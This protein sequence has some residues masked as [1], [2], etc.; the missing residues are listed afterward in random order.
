MRLDIQALRAIAVVSVVVY[1]VFGQMLPGG[2]VG[3]DIFFVISGYLITGQL[4]RRSVSA[5]RIQFADFWAR[6]ARR[7]LPASL[8]VILVTAITAF[9][10]MPKAQVERLFADVLNAVLYTSNWLFVVRSTNYSEDTAA[11]SPFQHFWSLS[12]EEQYYIL[13]PMLMFAVLAAARKF[14]QS[15]KR[16]LVISLSAVFATSL[17]FSIWLAAAMPTQAYFSTFTRAWEFAFGALLAILS[18]KVANKR[19]ASALYVLALGSLALVA[20]LFTDKLPFPSFW[21]L[22]P[23]AATGLALVVGDQRRIG[24]VISSK[25]IQFLGDLSYS[26]YLWH[27]A[28]L[29]LMPWVWPGQFTFTKGLVVIAAAIL[30]AWISKTAIEDPVRFGRISSFRPQR[31]LAVFATLM[32]AVIGLEGALVTI[33][34]ATAKV[35]TA[36][37][38]T[39]DAQQYSTIYP[40][41]NCYATKIGSKLKVCYGGDSHGKFKV[42]LIGDS[43]TRQYWSVIENMAVRNSWK[44]TLLSKSA[45]PLQFATNFAARLSEPSCETWNSQ[46]ADYLGKKTFDLIINSNAS[47]Y[48]DG[49]PKVSASYR[50][51]VAREL[52]KGTSWFVIKDNPKPLATILQCYAAAKSDAAQQC[53]VSRVD[54]MKPVDALPAAIADLSNVT[55]FDPTNLLCSDICKPVS[56]ATLMYRDFSHIS[57]EATV[58]IAPH[59]FAAIPQK[60]K[61]AN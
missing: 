6:R 11:T 21:A 5:G 29:T 30:L 25:P 52:A 59:L 8:T 19:L 50:K 16:F 24:K 51:L 61:T 27:W 56:N 20:F 13:W 41:K 14:A 22:L 28:I 55:V 26:L 57:W 17:M 60:F 36:Q 47:F 35:V 1:H 23:V 10:T 3:V 33:K 40:H 37:P 53:A 12:V 38:L 54:A 48:T 43:H 42:A 32:A 9:F 2:F 45:C 34:P 7:L 18:L 39:P 31:Q 44:L 46:L 49:D 58:M 15:P 4:Y